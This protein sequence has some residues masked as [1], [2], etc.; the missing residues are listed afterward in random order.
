MRRLAAGLLVVLAAS[1]AIGHHGS[2]H[3]AD[4]GLTA[5]ERAMLLSH[6]PW[7]PDWHG[8]PSN[9]V[10]RNPEA[11][12]FGQAL[13][14]DT[15]LSRDGDVSC[16]TCHRPERLWTDGRK[17]GKAIEE[18][19]RNTP[20]LDNLRF[21]RWF[22]WD[23]A[24]D[25]LWSQSFRP[26]LDP[27]EHGMTEAALAASVRGAPD[28]VCRYRRAFAADPPSETE[29]LVVDLGKALAAYIE[30]FVAGR[31]PFDDFRDAVARGDAAAAAA[32]PADARRGLR[33][34]VGK[35]R[36]SLCHFGPNFS[37]GE[38]HEIGIPIYRRSGG[39]DWGRYQ[40]IKLLKSSRFNLL[41]TFNDNPVLATGESTLHV[42]LA[43]QTFEQFKVP[44]L[45]NVA[46]TAPYMHNGHLADLAAVV[47]HYSTIDIANLHVAHIYLG[48]Q[49]GLNE[50]PP[51]DTVLRPLNL[52][53]TE[54]RDVV[55]FLESLSETTPRVPPRVPAAGPCSVAP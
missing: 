46:A 47:R 48:D 35:G 5:D 18:V 41:G 26:L 10:S 40:G 14:F 37:H 1:L 27:K 31:T 34:F 28:L 4:L 8:D 23:G 42:D 25:T 49:Y 19:D 52:A 13:F 51:V 39:V 43:P 38:F 6:G 7:P 54:I 12:A 45:R 2:G 16:A 53:D 24:N 21:S 11:V 29:L 9:R 55:A 20:S 44:S 3:A 17:L 15:R 30:T 33:I 36:C 32:Y 50:S 22:G